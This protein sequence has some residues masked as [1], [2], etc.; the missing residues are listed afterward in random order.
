MAVALLTGLVKR[1][2]PGRVL[3]TARYVVHPQRY[4]HFG[5]AFTYLKHGLAT[6]HRSDFRDDNRF[7]AAYDDNLRDGRWNGSWGHAD[8][9]WNMY[10]ACWAA[11]QATR[12]PG[13]FIE[14]GVYRGGLSRTVMEYVG[15]ARMHDR[16]YWLLDTFSGIPA[17]QIDDTVKHRH[18][19]PDS[20][21]EV[22]AL[23]ASMPNVRIVRGPVPAT[24]TAVTSERIAFVSLDMNVAAPERAA[25]EFLWPRMSPGAVMLIDDYG[26]HGHEAQKAEFDAFAAARGCDVLALPTGQG[27]LIK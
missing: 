17:E 9:E 14:C 11:T 15:F 26:W 8:P 21:A 12:I 19:Y 23:F 25:A 10:I 1:L 18:R 16:T 24:L 7:R 2:L 4:A 5:P 22:T 13:D 6:I 27:L 20:F 3:D